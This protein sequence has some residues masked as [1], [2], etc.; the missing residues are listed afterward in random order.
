MSSG[1]VSGGTI[2]DPLASSSG[3][4]FETRRDTTGDSKGDDAWRLAQEQLAASQR[5]KEEASHANDGKS[6]YEVLQAN[7]GG[8]T[9]LFCSSAAEL[10]G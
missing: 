5:Q 10:A 7:K 8:Y 6:L 3:S 4:K 1:F 9:T 2:D